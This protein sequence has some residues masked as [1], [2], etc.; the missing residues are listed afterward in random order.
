MKLDSKQTVTKTKKIKLLIVTTGL[1]SGGAEVMLCSLLSHI[2]RNYFEPSVISLMDKGIF[3]EQIEQLDIPVH[4]V[5]MLPGKTT[6]TSALRTIELIK[7]VK[8]DVIQGW[9]Y[10]GNLAAQFFNFFA[11]QKI[12]ILWSIH[13]SIHDISSE[14]LLTQGIIRFGSW[15]SQYISKVAFVS[16]KSQAQ[17]LQLGYSKD[18]SCI[19]PNGF[20]TTQ[21]Q[22]SVEIRQKFRQELNVSENTFLI[23]SLARYDPMKDHANLLRAAHVLLAELPE[24][25]FILLGN[26]VDYQNQAL[27]RLINELGIG[28][29][30]HLLGERGDVAQII[31]ALDVLTSSSAYGEAFPLVIGEAMSCGVP[32]VV[33]DIGDSGMIVGNTGKVVPPKNHI[34]LAKAWQE[35]IIMNRSA[36]VALGK[37]ARDRIVD[38]FSLLSI[39]DQ[40]EHLYQEVVNYEH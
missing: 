20:N 4:C 40:Y 29:N 5:G 38:K 27:I 30:V 25:K 7:Q 37:L 24:T 28:H 31:P 32:C 12:P 15:S 13:H 19:I 16:E 34:A 33:T 11:A 9:M 21:F 1:G 17:H 3:G 14:K 2:N 36:R 39:V 26:R 6:I 18:N 10:H 23:G 35:M 22:P 8:P